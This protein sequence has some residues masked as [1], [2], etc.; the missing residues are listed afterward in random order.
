MLLQK[1]V[2]LQKNVALEKGAAAAA[3]EG[4][5]SGVSGL[6]EAIHEE[7]KLVTAE[8]ASGLGDRYDANDLSLQGLIVEVEG[9]L[10]VERRCVMM[11]KNCV[12]GKKKRKQL[13]PA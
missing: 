2:L 1:D 9:G 10:F 5:L 8:D 7:G 4:I 11:R 12:K 3:S 6:L 13:K